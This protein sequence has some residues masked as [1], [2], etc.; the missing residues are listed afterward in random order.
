MAGEC[1][2]A[3]LSLAVTCC[4]MKPQSR[5]P[6]SEI[7]SELERI[8]AGQQAEQTGPVEAEPIT[9]SSRSLSVRRS[10]LDAMVEDRLSLSKSDVLSPV[11]STPVRVNPFSQRH[12][13]NGGRIKLFDTP[14]KSVISLT[15]TLPPPP[16]PCSPTPCGK[17]PPRSHR[18]C[19]SLPCTPEDIQ[20]LRSNPDSEAQ[21]SMTPADA[22]ETTACV[23]NLPN[24][25][26]DSM[27]NI[28]TE[29]EHDHVFCAHTDGLSSME[30][31]EN[32]RRIIKDSIHEEL[33]E[34]DCM[35]KLKDYAR[36]ADDSGVPTDLELMSI[37]H[38][39]EVS[40][41]EAMDCISSPSTPC[42]SPKPF[43]NG[44]SPPVSN[45]PPFLPPLPDLDNNNSPVQPLNLP[46]NGFHGVTTPVTPPEQDEVV[47]CS[48]CCL[49]GFSFPS[50]C[51]RG[52]RHNPYKNLNGDSATR[53]LL[54]RVQPPSPPAHSTHT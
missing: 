24:M 34:E 19:Q 32:E 36:L 8:S 33:E 40:V 48:G 21:P 7:V 46:V 27:V 38:L 1:P 52:T 45:R 4:C 28:Y 10:S 16:E 17:A 3:F 35:E 31:R 49:A 47:A 11:Q 22:N 51:I 2:P 13:L 29:V 18:R 20:S 6:F 12:D 25:D 37:D 39:T 53:E 14:S 41:E 26:S 23:V 5:P 43:T 15:F 9:S 42:D 50:L 54:C 30:E 44:W